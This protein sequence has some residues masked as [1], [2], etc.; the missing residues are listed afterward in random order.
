MS[1]EENH[2]EFSQLSDSKN[3][4]QVIRSNAPEY[5]AYMK[6]HADLGALEPYLKFEGTVAGDPHLGNFGPIPV[7]TDAGSRVMKFLNIDFDD[8]GR[9]PFVLDYVRYLAAIKAQCKPMKSKVVQEN[10][11]LGLEGKTVAPPRKVQKFLAMKISAYDEQAGQYCKHHCL[12]QGFKFKAG[13]IDPYKGT[14]KPAAI[15]KLFPGERVLSVAKR[16][17]ARGGSSDDVRIWAL[18]EGPQSRRRIME[19]KQYAAPGTSRYQPQP[20]AKKWLSEI[21]QAFWPDLTGADYDL[22]N[23]EGGGLFWIREK[24]VSLINVPYTSKKKSDVEFVMGL[25]AYDANLLGIA[26]GRQEQG[27]AYF[28]AIHRDRAAF[29]HATKHVVRG[30][31]GSARKAFRK[32]ASQ[33]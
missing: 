13:E 4:S 6:H 24:R 23:V 1:T 10:Y 22:V 19:L 8:A 9:A 15:S 17:E 25:A 11:L 20:L 18:V 7:M 3:L 12:E 29:H 31:L 32:A 21:R 28:A 14:I 2:P 30:Y 5:W 26:H 33:H 27:A 16:V